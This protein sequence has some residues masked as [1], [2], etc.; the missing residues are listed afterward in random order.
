MLSRN[1]WQNIFHD[2]EITDEYFK[3]CSKPFDGKG[4]KHHILPKSIFPELKNQKWNLVNL[5]Y[6]DHY[7]AHKLLSSLCISAENIKKMTLAFW[8]VSHTKYTKEFVDMETYSVLR[9]AHKESISGANSPM[10][11]VARSEETLR[12]IGLS[13]IGNKNFKGKHHTPSSKAQ[14]SAARTGSKHTPETLAHMSKIK[15]GNQSALGM[16]HSEETKNEMSRSRSKY[17]YEQYDMSGNLVKTWGN[18]KAIEVTGLF[19]MSLVIQVCN[20]KAKQHKGFIWKKLPKP[21]KTI[22]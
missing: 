11:G 19:T 10:F 14:L 13:K 1:L 7:K 2:S 4:E 6:S 5:S 17:Y 8:Q 21:S 12:K 20:G 22:P 16:R 15:M 9:K 18:Y 3:L